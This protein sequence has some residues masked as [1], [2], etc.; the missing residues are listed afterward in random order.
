MYW[1]LK[2]KKKKKSDESYGHLKPSAACRCVSAGV[3]IYAEILPTSGKSTS[4]VREAWA[5]VLSEP[6]RTKLEGHLARLPATANAK[7]MNPKSAASCPVQNFFFQFKRLARYLAVRGVGP[8][9]PTV[10]LN[11]QKV[12]NL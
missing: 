1:L 7:T 10:A 8:A 2:K 4:L 11:P 6:E 9:K 5:D 12:N 3:E